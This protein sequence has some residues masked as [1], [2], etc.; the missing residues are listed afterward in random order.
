MKN[1]WVTTGVLV[2]IGLAGGVTTVAAFSGKRDAPAVA[3]VVPR[4][5]ALLKCF[6]QS[7]EDFSIG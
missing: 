2:V 6:T 3:Q 4:D 5:A 1:F 7:V